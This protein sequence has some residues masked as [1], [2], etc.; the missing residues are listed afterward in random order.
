[1]H[2]APLITAIVLGLLL[3]PLARSADAVTTY[4]GSRTYFTL[5]S[6][7]IKFPIFTK[8][9]TEAGGILTVGG[10]KQ[11]W[12]DKDHQTLGFRLSNERIRPNGT[13]LG[14]SLTY[15]RGEFGDESFLYKK[16][17][18]ENTIATCRNPAHT[19]LFAD[20]NGVYI[21]W[22][23]DSKALGLYGL[24]SLIADREE[25]TIDLYTLL[26]DD[27][28]PRNLVSNARDNFDLHFGFGLFEGERQKTLYVAINSLGLAIGF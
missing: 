10:I 22:E 26:G 23:A 3:S 14:L 13:G 15:W 4:R 27:P 17:G 12:L 2:F 7:N 19:Y 21:A 18:S 25:Y 8:E 20:I 16:R 24:V 28:T 6:S 5:L 1:M 11:I 9:F